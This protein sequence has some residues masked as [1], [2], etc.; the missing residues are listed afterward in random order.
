MIFSIISSVFD[1]I[2]CEIPK[3]IEI[4]DYDINIFSIFLPYFNS[5]HVFMTHSVWRKVKIK[6]NL[7]LMLVHLYLTKI[8]CGTPKWIEIDGYSIDNFRI[9]LSYLNSIVFYH[10]KSEEKWNIK[11]NHKLMLVHLYL[12]KIPCGTPKWIEIDG[13]CIDNFRI[14]LSYLNS[15]VFYHKKSEEKFKLKETI[16]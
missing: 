7:K 1:T 15:I 12:T 11:W 6:W 4:Y 14:F 8:P 3:L 9:F 16:N 13:Y 5:I 2:S 10:K